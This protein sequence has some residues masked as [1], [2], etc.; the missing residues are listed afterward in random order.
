MSSRPLIL[1][2]AV[3]LVASSIVVL[4]SSGARA[5]PAGPA[6]ST[7]GTHPAVSTLQMYTSSGQ[8]PYCNE[9]RYT[10]GTENSGLGSNTLYFALRDPTADLWINFTLSDYNATRDGIGQPAFHAEV[11][12]NN[13][14]FEYFSTQHGLSYTFPATLKIGGTW[15]VSASAP[16]GGNVSYNITVGT[17]A[18]YSSGSPRSGS[19]VLPGESITT[20]WEAVFD[21]NDAPATT[22]TNVAIDGWYYGANDTYTNLFAGGIVTLPATAF[23]SYTWTVPANATYDD[24]VYVELWTTIVVNGVVAENHTTESVYLV[25][26]VVVYGFDMVANGGYCN[27]N[28]DGYYPYY[29]SGSYVQVCAEVGA[30]AEDGFTPVAG[31]PVAINFW[32]GT[33]V[34]TP[35]GNVPTTLTSNASGD[36]AFSFLA[37]Y[38]Q[39]SSYY[40]YPYY[41]SV[42]LTVT[43]TAAKPVPANGEYTAWSNNTFYMEPSGTTVGVT[44]SLNQLTYFPGQTITATW[45]LTSTNATQTGTVAAVAWYLYSDATGNFL[46]QG[47]ITSTATTGTLPVTLPAGFTGEFTIEVIASNA[48]SSFYGYVSAVVQSPTL[49]LNPNSITFAPGTSVTVTAVAWG[50]GSIGNAVIT[51][52]VYAIFAQGYFGYGG[53]GYTTTG[54]VGNGSSFTINVP[55]TGAPSSYEIYAYLASSTAGTVA[56]AYLQLTQSWGY[57]VWVG[58][59]TQSH[60]SDGSFQPGQTITVNYQIT[61]YGNAPLPVLYS[62]DVYLYSSQIGSMITTTSTSGSFQFTIPSNQ[63]S[64]IIFLEVELTGAYLQ[65]NSCDNG[66]CYGETALMVNANPSVLAEDLSPGSGLTV[67]WLILF[68][69]IAIVAI[70]GV[71]LYIRHRRHAQPPSGG[72]GAA[73]TTPMTP[74]APAPSTPGAT[75]WKAPPPASDGQP[76]LPTPPPGAT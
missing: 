49:A 39:F 47:T 40:Q 50:D 71:V 64:G 20:A 62:F 65:G 14:T 13:T 12:N 32:N 48:T 60:Y 17:F 1:A 56:S 25:G 33:K 3:L 9:T 24:D 74:P 72:G 52:Q 5:A 15:K 37:S 53:G 6:V 11:P 26:G 57:N 4:G 43:Y 30:G 34:V 70:V 36:I 35:P 63:P 28:S 51:Y 21:T 44:V 69:I 22:V 42:N 18:T 2:I 73:T 10:T 61:P 29:E 27:P 58:I 68:V 45:T 46:G 7:A 67:G 16:L 41:N 23:G 8:C 66:Y 55:S 54:T 75:E 31:L 59:G 19:I 38:P 76:P